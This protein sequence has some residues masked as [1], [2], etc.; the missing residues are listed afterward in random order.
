MGYI[1]QF[2]LV[3]ETTET[4]G[5]GALT[6]TGALA[7]RRTFAACVAVD[8]EFIYRLEAE[9]GSYHEIGRGRRLSNGTIQRVG[10]IRGFNGTSNIGSAIDLPGGVKRIAIVHG[11][12]E[13]PAA[14]SC[15]TPPRL[16][17]GNFATFGIA[18]GNG[19]TVYQGEGG[20]AIGSSAYSES[21]G[22]ALGIG[23]S[24]AALD[25]VALTRGNASSSARAA[26]AGPRANANDGWGIMLAGATGRASGSVSA[27]GGVFV[28]GASA[29]SS[30]GVAMQLYTTDA[31]AV[32]E[33]TLAGRRS[34][35]GAA[36]VTR[37][38]SVVQGSQYGTPT[39]ID[40]ALAS[41][42]VTGGVSL[43]APTLTAGASG[44]LT[45]TAPGEDAQTWAW[46]ATVRLT[47]AGL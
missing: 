37:I 8:D 46:G 18:W 25:S 15:A 12:H 9:D 43:S 1:K 22:A 14:M 32:Y 7:G 30:A 2:D 21:G 47:R 29:G 28:R 3:E 6:L 33:I 24:A 20:L 36:Y 44:L 45:L 39:V 31:L 26:L 23:A 11:A 27:H 38:T 10:D 35:D 42:F 34:S 5:T 13:A 41:V 17:T 40:A 4:T 19:A 16:E